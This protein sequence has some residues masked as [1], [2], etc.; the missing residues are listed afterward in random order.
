MPSFTLVKFTRGCSVNQGADQAYSYEFVRHHLNGKTESGFI[1][2]GQADTMYGIKLRMKDERNHAVRY[3]G[4]WT[5]EIISETR[6]NQLLREFRRETCV[7]PI[8]E[9]VKVG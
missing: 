3:Q 2:K 4:T 6:Y 9:L 5:W 1:K 8:I 7:C